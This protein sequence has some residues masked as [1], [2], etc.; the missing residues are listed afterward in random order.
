MPMNV[1][2]ILIHKTP[3]KER[4][5]I[6]KILLRSGK[7]LT[8][9]FYGGRGGGK[10][11]KGSI[12]E[13]GFML[14]INLAPR[15]KKIESEIHVAKEHQLIWKSDKIREDFKA[16]YLMCF[17]LELIG[18]VTISSDLEDETNEFHTLF[19]VLSNSLYYLDHSLI[20]KHFE[21]EG[22]LFIF[23]SKI[24]HALGVHPDIDACLFCAKDLEADEFVRFDHLNGGFS[25]HDCASKTDEF[26]SDNRFLLEELNA[27]KKLRSL[28][29]QL[30]SLQT[31]N[32]L[33]VN[34]VSKNNNLALINFINAHYHF[35]Q[36]Q[37][38]SWG[39][40]FL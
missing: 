4:D 3:Y 11:S 21:L 33:E 12:L 2:G 23:L 34:D 15:R 27:A 5:L 28:L 39:M 22:H 32:Y 8:V 35:T 37:F 31:K 20:Q 10:K 9:Y 36:E 7:V 19:S 14:K 30:R 16:F 40:I 18:K 38:K 13:V 29:G 17:Y 6:C 24:M 25:C 26:I 1:E